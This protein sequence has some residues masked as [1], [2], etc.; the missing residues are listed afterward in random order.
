MDDG[1]DCFGEAPADAPPPK[2][3]HP[4]PSH[5]AD[6]AA[7]A[8]VALFEGVDV[9]EPPP[10][11]DRAAQGSGSVSLWPDAPPL[12]TGPVRLVEDDGVGG[13]GFVA[14][15]DVRAGELL[16]LEAPHLTWSEA[17]AQEP[18]PMLRAVLESAQAAALLRAMAQLHPVALTP[19]LRQARGATHAQAV[20]LLLPGFRALRPELGEMEASTEL[21]RLCLTLQFNGFAA[22]LFLHQAI[23]NHGCAAEANCDKAG[24]R[25]SAGRMVS[26][27]RATRAIRQGG[28]C[29]ICY[30]PPL[31]LTRA[32][33]AERLEQF[34]F[35]CERERP[36]AQLE[37]RGAVSQLADSLH[38][39][40]A[41]ALQEAMMGEGLE[42]SV[43]AARSALAPL[44]R[45]CGAR[46]LA[47]AAAHRQLAAALRLKLGGT[48]AGGGGGEI[49]RPAGADAATLLLL[50]CSVEL[51]STQRLLLGD[52]HP[53]C[54]QTLHDIGT[55][56][57]AMLTHAPQ[58]LFRNRPE[59]GTAARAVR[60]GLEP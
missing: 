36:H 1:W 47:L 41:H 58:L 49:G 32:A 3:A 33:R 25:D 30:L 13:R 50:E 43:Q 2:L 11:P 54:A 4:P 29:L 22:G 53:E 5:A 39:S 23:F 21:L 37:P 56:L 34:D 18:L 9:P 59:W 26:A 52:A 27:V 44:R 10:A 20:G 31:E 8:A 55:A 38:L 51:W 17:H 16:L 57:Q 15:R 28:A 14:E 42:A 48:A 60:S 24:V 7:A 12:Y 19:A 35:G 40:T 6:A 46:H 45:A